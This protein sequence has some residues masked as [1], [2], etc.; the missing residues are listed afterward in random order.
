MFFSVCKL[1]FVSTLTNLNKLFPLVDKSTT[2]FFLFALGPEQL[3]FFDVLSLSRSQ[4]TLVRK[5]VQPEH[6]AYVFLRHRSPPVLDH[7]KCKLSFPPRAAEQIFF[8]EHF[9]K[10]TSFL[11]GEKKYQFWPNN[12]F[13][14]RH[15][16][17]VHSAFPGTQ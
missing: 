11:T 16:L 8:G 15:P 7:C 1:N 14:F 12:L 10:H 3:L 4:V 17:P 13:L 9:H 6:T 5:Q 2:T